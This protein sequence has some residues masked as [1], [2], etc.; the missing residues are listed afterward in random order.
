MERAAGPERRMMPMPPR[1]GGVEMATMVSS[2]RSGVRGGVGLTGRVPE[3][4][5]YR[6]EFLCAFFFVVVE[7][8]FLAGLRVFDVVFV[9]TKRGELRGKRGREAAT[10]VVV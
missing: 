2:G 5:G 7:D 1:P 3:L 6:F 10:F 4:I 8:A 9:W